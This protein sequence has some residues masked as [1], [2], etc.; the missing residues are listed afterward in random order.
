MIGQRFAVEVEYDG[1]TVIAYFAD[2]LVHLTDGGNL[3]VRL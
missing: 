3:R 1:A 2:P